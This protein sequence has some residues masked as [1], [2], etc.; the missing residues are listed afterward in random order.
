M[1]RYLPALLLATAV[2]VA[3]LPAAAEVP[4]AA[5]L[6]DRAIAVSEAGS[7]LADHDM[8]R[9]SI[10]QEET[11]K[12]GTSKVTEMTAVYYGESLDS[13]RLEFGQGISLVLDGTTSWAMRRGQLDTRALA[14]RMAG[15]TIRQI[16]FPLLLPFSLRMPGVNPGAVREGT[17]DDQ[18]VWVMEVDFDKDFFVVPS[19]DT[20]WRI[21]FSRDD[22]SVLGA[23]YFP[24]EEFRSVQEE[25]V[26]YRVL[27]R[28]DVDGLTLPNN[29][30]LDGI[31]ATGIENG[32]VRVTKI[33]TVTAGPYDRSIFIHPDEQARIESGDID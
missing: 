30:L 24:P 22:G 10:R 11:A 8:L 2:S 12:D 3:A 23:E 9:A 19:M 20:T 6:I 21:F 26:R 13:V 29:V 15:G 7:T 33:D 17:F 27:T 14:P 4:T 5:T 32:H 31:D 16:L 1:H 25:G 18:P 28:S